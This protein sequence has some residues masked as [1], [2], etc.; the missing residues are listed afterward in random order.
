MKNEDKQVS[1]T[2]VV[3]PIGK[4]R[5]APGFFDNPIVHDLIEGL[6]V[7]LIKSGIQMAVERLLFGDQG[8]SDSFPRSG[9]VSYGDHFTRRQSAGQRPAGMERHRHYQR[10]RSQFPQL[11]DLVFRN[12][13]DATLVINALYDRIENYTFASVADLYDIVQLDVPDYTYTQFGWNQA[14]LSQYELRNNPGGGVR[15]VMP[16][17]YPIES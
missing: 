9:R 10:V 6:L 4:I 17:P 2:I 15:L 7:P 13:E 11:E 14:Q 12:E 8:T 3:R 5:K 1:E 16:R